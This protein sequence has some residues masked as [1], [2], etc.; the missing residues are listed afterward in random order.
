MTFFVN[1]W[2][3]VVL[4][5]SPSAPQVSIVSSV[6]KYRVT[7]RS[8]DAEDNDDDSSDSNDDDESDRCAADHAK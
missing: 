4:S 6:A 1:K 3:I 5:F 7:S 8:L 2:L